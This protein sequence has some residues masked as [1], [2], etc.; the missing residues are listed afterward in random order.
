VWK[1]TV[2]MVRGGLT[3]CLVKSS[4]AIDFCQLKESPLAR[5]ISLLLVVKANFRVLKAETDSQAPGFKF[6]PQAERNAHV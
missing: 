5:A 1:W 4:G 2:V 3:E 6:S